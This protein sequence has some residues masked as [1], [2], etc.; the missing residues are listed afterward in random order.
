MQ[1]KVSFLGT[2]H[3]FSYHFRS[4]IESGQH[5]DSEIKH[6]GLMRRRVFALHQRLK[7]IIHRRNLDVLRSFLPPKF[8]YG[9]DHLK[10]RFIFIDLF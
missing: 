9:G 2:E 7:S 1:D 3:E 5:R 6:V 8:E 4:P 10:T